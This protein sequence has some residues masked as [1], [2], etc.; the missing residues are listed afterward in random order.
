MIFKRRYETMQ[1]FS[2]IT[3]FKRQT[4]N[5]LTSHEM[6]HI[7]QLLA[8]AVSSLGCVR[9]Q[10]S[11]A[12]I[13]LRFFVAWKWYLHWKFNCFVLSNYPLS[14]PTF[15]V[16]IL[17]QNASSHLC[18]RL[19]WGCCCCVVV[20]CLSV[21]VCVCVRACVRGVRACVRARARPE[22]NL[23]IIGL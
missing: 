20:L 7:W 3:L 9:Y 13:W 16:L 2:A 23:Y 15:C 22:T 12:C 1:S 5:M 10:I 11:S 18:F 6:E 8:Y 14:F 19:L 21:C 17:F 4:D